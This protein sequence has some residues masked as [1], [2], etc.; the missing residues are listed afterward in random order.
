MLF[1]LRSIGTYV[2]MSQ[3]MIPATISTMKMFNNGILILL[4][5]SLFLCLKPMKEGDVRLVSF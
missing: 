1:I 4:F 2:L 5:L 3:S